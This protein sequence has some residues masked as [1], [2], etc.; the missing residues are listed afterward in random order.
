M[1]KYKKKSDRI[2]KIAKERIKILFEEANK[3]KSKDFANKYVKLA[4][5]IS[6]KTKVPISKELK[7][8][9]CKH[10]YSHLKQ[11]ENVRVRINEKGIIYTCLECNKQMRFPIR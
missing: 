3:T 7:K 9:F 2:I 10:C 4:R 5:K 11:G 1:R 6:M 8:Q